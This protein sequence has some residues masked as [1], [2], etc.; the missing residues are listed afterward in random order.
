MPRRALEVRADSLMLNLEI[1]NL[2]IVKQQQF[3]SIVWDRVKEA[4]FCW[5]TTRRGYTFRARDEMILLLREVNS[6]LIVF[7]VVKG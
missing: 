4:E 1:D 2:E 3:G 7:Y 5:K 6:G